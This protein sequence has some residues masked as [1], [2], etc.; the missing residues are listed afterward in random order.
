MNQLMMSQESRQ[1]I[2]NIHEHIE[3]S[4]LVG[5]YLGVAEKIGIEKTI[6]VGSPNFT[7]SLNPRMG[8]EKYHENNLEVIKIQEKYPERFFSFVALNPLDSDN[9]KRLED[10]INLGARGLKLYYG[11]GGFHGKGPFHSVPVDYEKMD[12][13][14]DI[15]QGLD[16]PIIFHVNRI[17]YYPELLRFLV[18]HPKL[19]VLFPHLMISMKNSHR[20]K[21]VERLLALYPN[22]YTDFSFGRENHLLPVS[23]AISERKPEFVSF[24][25]KWSNRIF[26]GTDLVITRVK[27]KEWGSYVESMMMWSRAI[28]E[29]SRYS[30]N[31]N[32]SKYVLKGLGLKDDCLENIYWN[33]FPAFI[34]SKVYNI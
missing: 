29:N 17:K 31:F 9:K 22:I 1:K 6:F 4:K 13:I 2:V 5:D 24:F 15:C 8:F 7:L 26:F 27:M 25:K 3:S 12:T 11:L 18:K 16:L 34:N 33:N 21:K 32:D 23:K 10:Y 20:L 14:F 30:V 19:K 28:L